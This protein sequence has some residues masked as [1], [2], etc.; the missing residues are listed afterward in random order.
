MY[1]NFRPKSGVGQSGAAVDIPR[2][3]PAWSP[4]AS[5]DLI[6]HYQ[7]VQVGFTSELMYQVCF[8]Y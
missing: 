2:P 4:S 6:N 5:D 3:P 1:D 8:S 7:I